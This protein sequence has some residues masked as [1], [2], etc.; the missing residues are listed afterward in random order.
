MATSITSETE[1][2]SVE[3]VV[4][5]HH[6]YK[7]TWTPVM[8]EKLGTRQEDGNLHDKYAVCAM[9]NEVT[10]GHVPRE[11]S[12]TSWH[13]IQHGGEM[14]CEVIGNRKHSSTPGKGL[15][16]PCKYHFHGK[17]PLIRKLTK[18][19]RDNNDLAN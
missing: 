12:K 16:V 19:F 4:R 15:E 13:F 17:A 7:L 18:L 1:T 10:V 14:K 9:K 5:G 8:G 2:Y 11:I 3:S 6:V